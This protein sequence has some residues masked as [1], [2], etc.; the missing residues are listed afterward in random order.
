MP[1]KND[2]GQSA[3]E[4]YDKRRKWI[5]YMAERAEV[6]HAAFRV[7]VWLALRMN[8]DDQCCWY[9]VSEIAKRVGCST[10][11]V[12][13]ATKNLEAE[14]LMIVVRTLGRRNSYRIT[15]PFF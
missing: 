12:S 9:K 3:I 5:D 10:K 13:E 4:F 14:G 7:G 8:G 1:K 11:T 6:S 2:D 15:A